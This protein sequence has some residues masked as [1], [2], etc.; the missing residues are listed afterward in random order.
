[1]QVVFVC[2]QPFCRNSLFKCAL[3]PINAKNSQKNSILVVQG[4]SRSSLLINLKSPSPVLVMISRYLC[5]SA[6]VFT[7]T[8]QLAR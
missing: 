5:L 6:I 3:Q 7:H 4:R 1:M 8:T 2:L